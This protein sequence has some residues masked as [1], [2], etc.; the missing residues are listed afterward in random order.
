MTIAWEVELK[1]KNR[2]WFRTSGNPLTKTRW[3][4]LASS[5]ARKGPRTAMVHAERSD[6]QRPDIQDQPQKRNHSTPL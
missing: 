3:N 4:Y 5:R 1:L 6:S 2:D